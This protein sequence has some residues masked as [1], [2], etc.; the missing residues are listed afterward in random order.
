[1]DLADAQ[2]TTTA[3]VFTGLTAL[4][5]A[6]IPIAAILWTTNFALRLGLAPV[7]EQYL[8]LIL[9]LSLAVLYLTE[10]NPQNRSH[11]PAPAMR[12]VLRVAALVGLATLGY[13]ALVYI[14]LL[15]LIAY[16][17][18]VLTFIGA[19]T[20]VLVADGVRRRAGFALFA[21]VALFFF[22]AL[23]ADR[24]P[25]ALIGRNLG[26]V[27]LV[28][29][30]GFDPS[31]VY[32]TPLKVGATVVIVFVL[33]GALLNRAG[34]GE[35]F[36]DLALATA[37]RTRGG[38][39][40]ISVVASALL[41]SISGSAVSNVATTGV[42][43]IPLM[44]RGGYSA[45]DAGA[46][47]AIASTGG[48]LT[49]PIMGAAAFLMAEFLEIGY[50][51][52]VLAAIVPAALYYFSVFVQV[53]LIA[54]RE[55]ITF[56]DREVVPFGQV[57]RRG[58]HFLLPFAMLLWGLFGLHLEPEDSALVSCLVL[59]VVG[60]L[61]PYGKMKLTLPALGRALTETGRTMV[62]LILVVAAAGF[63]IGILN[64]TGLSFA[65]TLMLVDAVGS[66]QILLLAVSAGICILLGMGMP[67]AGVYVLLAALVAP[68]L[69]ET[70]IDPIAAHLFILY[71]G[72]M[73]MVTPP[74]ALAAF[75]AAAIS[76]ANP[77]STG[78]ASVRLGWAAF[79]IPF[80]FVGSTALVLEGPVT[81]TILATA[82]AMLGI[83]LVSAAIVGWS[84]GRIGRLARLGLALLGL[85][86][87]P[88]GIQ[89]DAWTTLS[90][91]GA[92]AGLAVLSWRAFVGRR[93][94]A[95]MSK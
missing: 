42:I 39:A 64:A 25:G 90:G 36:T 93:P 47:E 23:F 52:V 15:N 68:A 17:P 44:R 74:I 78:L 80:L 29:Y 22:Y 61:R 16:R 62:E 48:Q 86:T 95:A 56:V 10:A 87:M 26:L 58:W 53:D 72:M 49:P 94:K 70:G 46:I 2:R 38:A 12:W 89:G 31:A 3:R 79:L 9:G 30:I 1:M 20:V 92:A 11:P 28:Q 13:A 55:N 81:E 18:P 76:R 5:A 4:C 33:F 40:K 91:A 59:A 6:A 54:A 66:N 14:E 45:R 83:M 65:L 32:A 43:T 37:G 75:A 35:F 60:Y 63:V 51:Q 19:V 34:G 84:G 73:S 21:I 27:P 88:T 41:G 69:V 8:A 57:M 82:R 67:T 77:M 50:L 85:L 24:V 7:T 71:F